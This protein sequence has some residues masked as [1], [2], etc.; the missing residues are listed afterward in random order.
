MIP[1]TSATTGELAED[2]DMDDEKLLILPLNDAN[3]KKISQIIASDTAR[4]ILDVIASAPRSA[5]EIANN[6]AIPLTTVQ[7][8][9]EK[10]F[11]AGLVKV[12]RT[13]YSKKM[14][15]V[16]LYA[17]RRKFVVIAPEKTDKKDVIATLKRYLMVIAFAVVGS[18]AIEFLTVQMGGFA[19]DAAIRSLP[20]EAPVPPPAPMYAP[21]PT[22]LPEKAFNAVPGF[23]LFAHPGLWFLFGCLFVILVILLV[24][25]HGRKKERG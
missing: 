8:N 4:D 17:P 21:S 10:L 24:E 23:D 5:S 2:T 20:E 3:S 11:D 14:K 16:K 13:K 25:H 1:N 18:G 22:P 19:E 9:L 6:L 7:Y 15:P 12:E